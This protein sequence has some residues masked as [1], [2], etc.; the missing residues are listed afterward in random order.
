MI[1]SRFF[2]LLKRRVSSV[3]SLSDSRFSLNEAGILT[4]LIPAAV[5][6]VA[7]HDPRETRTARHAPDN[8]IHDMYTSFVRRDVRHMAG[9]L[10]VSLLPVWSV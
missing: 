10:H 3:L 6:D 2:G 8:Y 1:S 4:F 9:P 7:R 5:V